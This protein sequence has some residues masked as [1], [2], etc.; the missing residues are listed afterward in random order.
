MYYKKNIDEVFKE[1]NTDIRGLSN[2]EARDRLQKYGP[3]SIKEKKGKS[4]WEIFF[5]QFKSPLI[6]IL[7][8]AAGFTFIIGH[9]IDMGVIMAAVLVNAVVGVFQEYKAEKA[10]RAI[11]QLAAPKAI[12]I[13]ECEE[14]RIDSAEVVPGDVLVLLAG[15][16]I[17]ADM[18]L[19]N[20]NELSIDEA[21]L[22]GESLASDKN[23]EVIEEENVPIADQE[24]MVFMGT[25]V[26]NGTGKGIVVKTGS[27]TELGKIS[28]QL[29]Y[30]EKEET[31]LQKRLGDF[32][33][34]VG[35]IS[36]GLS[37]FVFLFG[38]FLQG[39]DITDMIVFAISMTV[40]VIPEGLPVVV[41]ITMAIGLNRMA[42][43]NAIVRKLIA[44]ETLGSC[45]YICTDK[46]GTIT[47]NKMTV[48][49]T[50]T[51][52]K[53]YEFRGSGYNPEGKVLLNGQSINDD[54]DL[55]LLLLTGLLCN[56]S[57]LFKEDNSWKINGDPTEGA[58]VVAAQ[59]FGMNHDEVKNQY[60]RID[61]LPFS[62]KR[63]YMTTLN[64]RKDEC[65]LF[66]KGSP[67]KILE[68]S[69]NSDNK[70][71]IEQYSKMAESGLRV[72]GFGRKYLNIDCAENIDLE[73]ESSHG[74]E[75][76]GFQGIIDPP[77][78]SAIEALKETHK[79]GIRTVMLTG[80]HKITATT[81]A[82]QIN[83]F[84]EGDMSVTG[85][86]IDSQSD[87]F[88]KDNIEKI[89]VYARVSPSH[90]LK[91]VDFLQ[92]KGN[93][94]AVTGDGVNDAPALKKAN[95]GISMGQTGTDVAKE[96]S[97]MILKDDNYA[98][99]FEAVKV[100]RVIFDNIQKV[101][102]FL[103][104]TA[105]GQTFVIIASLF[106][107]LPLPFLATQ[108]LWINLV[109]NGLQDIALAYEPGERDVTER[110]PRNPS[111]NIIDDFIFK[112][113]M[114]VGIVM[115]IGT[116]FLFWYKL[117]QGYSLVY[118]RTTAFNTIVFFQFF[119]TLNSRSFTKSILHMSPF[120]NPFLFIS[121]FLSLIAQIS[122]LTFEPLQY[123]FS[124]TR[125]DAITWIQTILVSFS[126]IIVI[127]IDKK[128]RK[129][130]K[131]Q[132]NKRV[133]SKN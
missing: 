36:V 88:L 66:V 108:V 82:K 11:M 132:E 27:Y 78:Q 39:M 41:T 17:P 52:G 31:P 18:R 96:A 84:K 115:L 75:F 14:K 118:A 77:R 106:L 124:T 46:T 40:A 62:S 116:L 122:V 50:Y 91:I 51:N 69:G 15:N 2:E 13:R 58:L 130:K 117:N 54:K 79:A 86:E 29:E 99:I 102:F 63:Q 19:F 113:L 92:E 28:R 73:A 47:E 114:L 76:V 4:I 57:E 45:N 26:A 21:A 89:K 25:V 112:R 43:R 126:I 87:E 98:T 32:S 107:G 23:A 119:S 74:L 100:G 61:E 129:E 133:M 16:R 95:I 64:R 131:K 33:R 125:L 103:L 93:V 97:D 20:T 111:E 8:I 65:L 7:L 85:G 34:K 53:E 101:V 60:K 22:T 128:I 94:V 81:I 109:T 70:D 120:S 30:T 35:I 105:V 10:M 5:H 110:P 48:T 127:E 49:R 9:Y 6:Y 67:E 37:I 56:D 12:V 44:V 123:I 1:L 59:K 121:L 24:N 42:K 38:V 3:N 71:L 55:H 68:F 104:S 83:I 80:D 90:K 72:L